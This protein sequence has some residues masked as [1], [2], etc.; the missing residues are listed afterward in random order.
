MAEGDM[1]RGGRHGNPWA[2]IVG[3]IA[4]ERARQD[5]KWGEQRFLHPLYWL[6]ILTE[7]VGEVAEAVIEPVDIEIASP[8]VR[9][10]LVQVAAVA[11]CWLEAIDRALAETG[12]SDGD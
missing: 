7:E 3:D 4:T 1:L 8:E 10:E 5:E 12:E 11:V 2:R 6:A 9:R